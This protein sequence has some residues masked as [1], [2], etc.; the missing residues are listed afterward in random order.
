MTHQ[1]ASSQLKKLLEMSYLR[2]EPIG[3]ESYYELREPLMRFCLEV[4]KQ[5]G[6]PIRLFV[7]FLRIWYT[8]TELQQR[9]EMLLPEALERK[10]VLQALW[11]EKMDKYLRIATYL[12]GIVDSIEKKDVAHS[13]Q[14]LEQ[15]VAIYSHPKVWLQRA[16]FL[17]KLERYEEALASLEQALEL[18]PNHAPA[19]K[20]PGGM[21]NQL[22]PDDKVLE[23]LDQAMKLDCINKIIWGMRGVV[24]TELERYEEALASLDKA[25]ELD[26]NGA[27][28]W[29]MRGVVLTE[30]ERYEEALASLDKAIELDPNDASLWGIRGVVLPELERYEEALVSLNKAIE[31]DPNDASCWC[32]RGL[33][34]ALLGC[35]QEA[36]TSWEKAIALSDQSSGIFFNRVAA[37]LALNRWDEGIAALDDALNRFAHADEPETGDTQTII[38]NLFNSTHD[39]AIWESRIKTLIELYDK[40]KVISALEIGVAAN[41][42]MLMSEMVSDKARQTWLEVW[43]ELTS[44]RTQFQL[45][46]RLLNAAVRYRGTKGDK[47]VLLQLPIEERNLLKPLLGIDQP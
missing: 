44:D 2:S 40:H 13:L 24:L 46:L 20:I 35:Y 5:R 15:L 12:K 6:K 11:A 28:L 38:R 29:G 32:I 18:D 34:L 31:L 42:P 36:I 43:Q 47:R 22:E 26:P 7:D 45:P 30:L 8:R 33:I 39:A 14:L 23:S 17:H 16:F 1:T 19:Q 9:L 25:I 21:L 27:S 10:Y 4:K 37:L 41:I 3:R